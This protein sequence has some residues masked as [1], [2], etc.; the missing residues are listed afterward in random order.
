MTETEAIAGLPPVVVEQLDQVLRRYPAVRRVLL[1]G[2][3]AKGTQRSNSDIDL[4]LEAPELAFADYLALASDLEERV[5]PY[6][7]DLVLRH[8]IENPGFIEHI[9]RVGRVVYEK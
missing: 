7:L 5:F 3:R 8:H 2:S 6:S 9:D 1:F 4:C